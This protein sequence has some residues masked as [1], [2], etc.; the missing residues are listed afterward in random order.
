MSCTN[1][2]PVSN[3]DNQKAATYAMNN[4]EFA[5]FLEVCDAD[6]EI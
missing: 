5:R 6:L 1:L 4:N 3:Q 2:V